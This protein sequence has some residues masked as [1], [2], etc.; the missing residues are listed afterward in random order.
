MLFAITSIIII[1]ECQKKT[2]IVTFLKFSF[3]GGGCCK[4][5]WSITLEVFFFVY[6]WIRYLFNL[7]M[8]LKSAK[9][10]AIKRCQNGQTTITEISNDKIKCYLFDFFLSYHFIKKDFGRVW[11]SFII[12]SSI[13]LYTC[14]G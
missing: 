6:H 1:Y 14:T 10:R 4:T 13:F 8:G 3:V 5:R 7:L 9:I 2:H 12:H 11:F